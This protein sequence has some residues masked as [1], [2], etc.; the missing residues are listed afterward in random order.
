[1]LRDS[2]KRRIKACRLRRTVRT[3]SQ[4]SWGQKEEF[5]ALI[6]LE[7]RLVTNCLLKNNSRY[8]KSNDTWFCALNRRFDVG[9]LF[10]RTGVNHDHNA[11]N[12]CD[13]GGTSAD[14]SDNNNNDAPD[15]RRLLTGSRPHFKRS[16]L[17]DWWNCL[18]DR[19]FATRE[20][21][22]F[23]IHCHADAG[24]AAGVIEKDE[25]L[26]RRR[27]ELAISAEFERCFRHAIRLAR[28]VDSESIRFSFR[29]AYHGIKKWRSNEKQ[30]A[31]DQNEQRQS[32]WISNA[33]HAP[34]GPPTLHSCV[35]ENMSK[36]ESDKDE[37]SKISQQL[38]TM[39]ENVMAHL[40]CHDHA[41]FRE[42]APF[43]QIIIERDPRCAENSGNVCAYPRGLT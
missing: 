36:R 42:C 3:L 35:E 37:N 32:G 6:R 1:M 4:L 21:C 8:E 16:S 38:R 17:S 22:R 26:Q 40:V 13:Y 31:Q 39:I 20:V 7:K 28:S 23:P 12:H 30:C 41:N 11:S 9:F 14:R 10:Q 27:I 25:F 18:Q 24:A 2:A 34:S 33:T 19:R 43:E 29:H 5:A 15:G